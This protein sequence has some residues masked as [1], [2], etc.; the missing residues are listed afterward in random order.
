MGLEQTR[1]ECNGLAGLHTDLEGLEGLIGIF[2]KW[3]HQIK[4][5][6]SP[7][8]NTNPP[9]GRKEEKCSTELDIFLFFV[10]ELAQMVERSLRM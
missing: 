4:I 6:C 8:R 7:S 2:S 5:G 1:E 3:R 9:Q 10:G